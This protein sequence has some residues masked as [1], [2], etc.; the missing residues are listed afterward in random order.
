VANKASESNC[1]GKINS[2]ARPCRA[3]HDAGTAAG[4]APIH[5]TAPPHVAGLTDRLGPMAP[6]EASGGSICHP[7]ISARSETGSCPIC[8][9]AA[10]SP[11]LGLRSSTQG[12][13]RTGRQ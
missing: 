2:V 9:I 13:N 1:N 5:K 12:P 10:V 8:G 7:L 6:S 11:S 3:G 4:T